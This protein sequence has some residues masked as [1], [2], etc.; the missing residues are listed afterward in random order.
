MYAKERKWHSWVLE[1]VDDQIGCTVCAFS[2]GMM[3]IG[4]VQQCLLCQNQEGR[5]QY[6]AKLRDNDLKDIV[7]V[8]RTKKRKS[9]YTFEKQ[10]QTGGLCESSYHLLVKYKNNE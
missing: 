5:S 3:R 1:P 9:N 8:R 4:A 10:G 6:F 2:Y 7:R